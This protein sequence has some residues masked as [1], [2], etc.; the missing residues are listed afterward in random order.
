MSSFSLTS[1]PMRC[2][3]R[4]HSGVGQFVSSGSWRCSTRSRCSGSAWRRGLR[5]GAFAV[6]GASG[7]PRCSSASRACRL[8]SSSASVSW[9]NA[10]C[11]AVMASV[12]VPNFQRFRR[13]SSKLTFSSLA[14]AHAISRA[15][16]CTC[17]CNRVISTD[18][19]VD[20]PGGSCAMSMWGAAV[21]PSMLGMLHEPGRAAHRQMRCQ[22]R[23][24]ATASRS[25][26]RDDAALSQTLPWQADRQGLELRHGQ[27]QCGSHSG[28]T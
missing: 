3:G 4:P 5:G 25:G 21:S 14:C 2:M 17:C 23:Q 22:R 18:A 19:S 27:L 7:R 8:A 11:W 16:D 10:R 20:R 13:A 9:N 24:R 6:L 28:L 1:S 15:W 26:S 12:L